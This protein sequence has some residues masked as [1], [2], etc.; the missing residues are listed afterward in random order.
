MQLFLAYFGL[1]LFGFKTTAWFAAAFALT[2]YSSAYLTE[3]WRGCVNAIP[4]GQWEASGS[5]A[6]EGRM[7]AR[8]GAGVFSG[9][10]EIGRVTSGGFS[11]SLQHPIAMAYVD[12]ACAAPGTV[13]AVANGVIDENYWLAGYLNGRIDR[14]SGYAVN[15]YANWFHSGSAFVGDSSGLGATLSYYRELT[16]HLEATAAAGLDNISR[17][18]PLPDQTTLSALV[19]LRY[20]F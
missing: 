13:L 5:L 3:I 20:S 6:L 10:Q 18:D 1:A 7:A 14:S 9:S 16:D 2:L 15:V 8:E 19:G 17:S 11:P 4:R 12:S